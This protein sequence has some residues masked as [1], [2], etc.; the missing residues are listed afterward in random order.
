MLVSSSACK[1]EKIYII[2]V[3]Y[4]IKVEIKCLA[5]GVALELHHVAF[6]RGRSPGIRIVAGLLAGHSQL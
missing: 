4:Q 1:R 2:K 3:T 5:T 6:S